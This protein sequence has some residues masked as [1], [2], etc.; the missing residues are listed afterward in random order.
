MH[1]D[2]VAAWAVVGED[3]KIVLTNIHARQIIAEAR[4][5]RWGKGYRA[6][7]VLVMPVDEQ[8]DHVDEPQGDVPDE[9]CPPGYEPRQGGTQYASAQSVSLRIVKEQ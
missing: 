5:R 3:G 7:P 4:A 9:A 1:T 6:I 8:S 2:A